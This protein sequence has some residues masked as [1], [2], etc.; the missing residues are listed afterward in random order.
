MPV[1]NQPYYRDR[2]QVVPSLAGQAYYTNK[3]GMMKTIVPNIFVTIFKVIYLGVLTTILVQLD[4]QY[5]SIRRPWTTLLLT[6][7]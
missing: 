5:K 3:K 4:M 1:V 7:A 6:K 2:A